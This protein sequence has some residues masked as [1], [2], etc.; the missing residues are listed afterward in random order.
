MPGQV[1]GLLIG[2][3]LLAKTRPGRRVEFRLT[4]NHPFFTEVPSGE[5]QD[6]LAGIVSAALVQ[7][8]GREEAAGATI[9]RIEGKIDQILS[10][11]MAGISD[12]NSAVPSK[13]GHTPLRIEETSAEKPK[14]TV[15]NPRAL[16]DF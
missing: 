10:R 11:V 13:Q 2:G 7:N 1:P 4:Y 8:N 6:W 9:Q 15:K 12:V 5:R 16:M 14:P 3:D